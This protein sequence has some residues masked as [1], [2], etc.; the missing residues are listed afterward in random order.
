MQGLELSRAYY[1]QFGAPMLHRDFPQIES[2]VAAGLCG[3]GSECFGFD[4]D[5][6]RDHD[7]EPGFCLFLPGEDVID[8]RTA[9][10]LERAYS[11]LPKEFDGARRSLVAPVGGSRRGVLRMAD[12]FQSKVGAP[13]G[14]LTIGQWLDTPEFYLAEATNGAVFRDDSGVF[15]AIR[16]RLSVLPEDIRKK[17]LAGEL[18]L[19][20]QSGQYNFSRCLQHKEPAAAQL[21]AIE[22]VKAALHAVFLLNRVYQPYYKWQFRALRGLP[23]LGNL[24]EPLEFLLTTENR[25]DLGE[26]KAA[27]I[28]DI[29]ALLIAALQSQDLT[30]ATCGDLEQHAYAVNDGIDDSALRN[31]HVLAAIH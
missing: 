22:F 28:E 14:I 15:S 27:I 26:T 20:G 2:L 31:L 8:R 18:L 11:K 13:D 3:S 21:A 29:A 30:T 4:D 17:K 25:G 6:S 9:F 19:M 16:A 24:A 5:I 1:E 23:V 10:L 12:F 7:F